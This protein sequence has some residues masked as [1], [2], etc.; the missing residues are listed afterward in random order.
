[1]RLEWAKV[2]PQAVAAHRGRYVAS[3]RCSLVVHRILPL[4]S[5]LLLPIHL[6][7]GAPP[8]STSNPLFGLQIGLNSAHFAF[9]NPEYLTLSPDHYKS[10]IRYRLGPVIH[11]SPG[12]MTFLDS[13]LLLNAKGGK[14]VNIHAQQLGRELNT[15]H[16]TLYYLSLPILGGIT[17]PRQDLSP[18]IFVGPE[19][20]YLLAARSST[21]LGSADTRS[22]YRNTDIALDL[23]VGVLG[24]IAT[25]A[26]SMDIAYSWG[27]TNLNKRAN[28]DV[29]H[30]FNRVLT[31]S[32]GVWL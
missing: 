6:A 23:G 3:G 24:R 11:L 1:M 32:V 17:F 12:R 8:I 28:G 13:G 26:I 19:F 30:I 27:F 16:E 29:H 22:L 9:P 31:G 2:G 5:L 10:T 15:E 4:L 18:R 7:G 20:N 25:H 21:E 14:V